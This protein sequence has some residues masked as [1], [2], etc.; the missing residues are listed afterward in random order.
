MP[1]LEDDASGEGPIDPGITPF[2]PDAQNTS[3]QPAAPAAG[4]DLPWL[5]AV[6]QH[7]VQETSDL[8]RT[9]P[10]TPGAPQQPVQSSQPQQPPS[11][12]AP[13]PPV[14]Q[15]AQQ[16]PDVDQIPPNVR[17]LPVREPA[18]PQQGGT[19]PPDPNEPPPDWVVSILEPTVT[20][21]PPQ[22]EYEPEELAHIMPWAHPDPDQPANATPN[23]AA[24]SQLP[25]WLREVTVQ[26]T[27]QAATPQ[28]PQEPAAPPAYEDF[29]LEGI[30]PFMPPV[31]EEESAQPQA[32]APQEQ[33]PAWL[34]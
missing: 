33:V 4:V 11:E 17:Q 5:Q 26:E 3:Q 18:Q 13:Q 12:Q 22:Q 34:R 10:A 30:E 2:T 19:P 21:P 6:Q 28:A 15:T 9:P 7:S 14:E 1:R 16:Q 8:R 31:V 32:P 29:A 24:G 23:P 27:L 25:P 20:P